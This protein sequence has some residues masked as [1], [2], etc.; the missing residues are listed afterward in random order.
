MAA[1]K[2]RILLIGPL[3]NLEANKIGGARVSFSE[4]IHCFKKQ[5]QDFQIINTKPFDTGWKR[6]LNPF[7][8]LTRFFNHIFRHDLVFLNV[9]Q[10]GTKLLAPLLFLFCRLLNKKFVFRPFG[11]SLKAYYQRYSKL[12]KWIFKHSILKADLFFL[13]TQELVQYFSKMGGNIQQLPTSRDQPDVSL[14]SQ[15]NSYQKRF[16]FMGHIKPSKGIDH[17]LEAKDLLDNSYTIHLYG[18]IADEKYH[19]LAQKQYSPYQGLLKKAEVLAT[20]RQYDVLV[21]PTFFSGEGYPG[22]IIEAYSLG[23]PVIATE[24]K[25]IPEIVQHSQTGFLIAPQSTQALIEA[26]QSFDQTNYQQF[27][28]QAQNY[29][30]TTFDADIVVQRVITALHSLS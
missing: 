5:N 3:P 2:Y 15:H 14:T 11:G 23:M 13:Q 19:A 21:L 12:Q 7:Y 24:W 28:K 1:A 4:L 9:S 6:V 26:M 29:F 18:P 17:L 16:V 27:S 20:L 10:G 25:A 30:S 22:A 8:I